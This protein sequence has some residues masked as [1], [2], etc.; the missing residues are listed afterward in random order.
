MNPEPNRRRVEAAIAQVDSALEFATQYR[1][2][3]Q[4]GEDR[5]DLAKP[6]PAAHRL[7]ESFR[8]YFET[9]RSQAEALLVQERLGELILK[10][11]DRERL[12]RR[13][14][15][16]LPQRERDRLDEFTSCP[17]LRPGSATRSAEALKTTFSAVAEAAGPATALTCCLL[18]IA[19]A[20]SREQILQVAERIDQLYDR[21]TSD[22]A[23]IQALDAA[24]RRRD[25]RPPDTNPDAAFQTRFGVLLAVRERLW[26]LKPGRLATHFLLPQVVEAYLGEEPGVGDSLGLA[27][28][29]AIIIGKLGFPVRFHLESGLF[30]LEVLLGDRSV[31]WDVNRPSPLSFVPVSPSRRLEHPELFAVVYSSLATAF[32]AGGRFDKAL[33]R[34]ERSLELAPDNPAT[35]SSIA[36]CY[37]QQQLPESAVEALERSLELAPDSAETNH[38]LGNAYALMRRWPKA[39]EAYKKA[40]A[41]KPGYVEAYNNL[42]FTFHRAGSDQQAIDTFRTAIALRPEYPQAYFNLGIVYLEANRYEEAAQYLREAARLAPELVQVHYNLGQAYYRS[43]QLDTAIASYRKAIRLNPKH[44]GAW[45]NLGIAYRDKGFKDKAVEALER[46]VQLNPSLMK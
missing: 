6:S 21:I 25:S 46:A 33:E 11:E 41:L 45:Y 20:R 10:L 40:I 42:G 44:Y 37:I 12:T 13:A 22:P 16:L 24:A 5:R 3:G 8:A 18:L 15:G 35:H 1:S 36:A 29:D 17:E 39:I 32:Y 19:S 9:C 34:Y 30:Y 38:S 28:L 43:G 2:I 27:T 4:S 7:A 31:Y 23:V 14:L 26:Q